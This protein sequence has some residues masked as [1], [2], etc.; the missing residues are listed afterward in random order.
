[1]RR[2]IRFVQIP[3]SLLDPVD[4]SEGGKTGINL[5]EAKNS[6]GLFY[7]PWATI[8]DT[9]FLGTLPAAEVR[10]GMLE[11]VKVAVEIL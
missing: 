10:S 5:P 4:N 6:V 11:V 8:A 3:T 9:R 2:G 1:M 7:Q